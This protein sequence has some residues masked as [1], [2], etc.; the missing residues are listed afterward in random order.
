VGEASC[1]VGFTLASADLGA[2][3]PLAFAVLVSV[4]VTTAVAVA[5]AFAPEA[6]AS[7][8]V[9][10]L[11]FLLGRRMVRGARGLPENDS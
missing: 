1:L 10:V 2:F 8:A 7:V 11:L 3:T 9:V 4:D 5:V 6:F